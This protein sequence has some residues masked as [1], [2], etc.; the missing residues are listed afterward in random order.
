MTST[1]SMTTACR[2]PRQHLASAQSARKRLINSA[3]CS[4]VAQSNSPSVL[5]WLTPSAAQ[6]SAHPA[7]N[8]GGE[9]LPRDTRQ[10]DVAAFLDGD[11]VRPQISVGTRHPWRHAIEFVQRALQQVF[12]R[13]CGREQRERVARCCEP[14][15]VGRE[16]AHLHGSGLQLG[17]VGPAEP[18]ARRSGARGEARHDGPPGYPGR[19]NGVQLGGKEKRQD[20]RLQVVMRQLG[21]R[22]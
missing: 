21:V 22:R 17:A 5:M 19:C 8:L 10:A 11:G 2:V 12:A 16:P 14:G 1:S 4:W 3:T 13:R 18:P 15:A 7:L 9:F 6:R 20:V